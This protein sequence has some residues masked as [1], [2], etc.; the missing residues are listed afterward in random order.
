MAASVGAPFLS[1]LWHS[2]PFTYPIAYQWNFS[3][4]LREE[5]EI[6][7]L[8]QL[9]GWADLGQLHALRELPLVPMQIPHRKFSTRGIRFTR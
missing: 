1:P 9:R 8:L 4:Q 7:S 6:G 3:G 2:L 5:R